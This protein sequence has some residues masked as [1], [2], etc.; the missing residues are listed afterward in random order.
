MPLVRITSVDPCGSSFLQAHSLEVGTCASRQRSRRKGWPSMKSV[1]IKYSCCYTLIFLFVCATG[2]AQL[3]GAATITPPPSATQPVVSPDTL[4][5]DTPRG[6]VLNFL[7]YAHRGD[8]ATAAK[9][10]QLSPKSADDPEAIALE[11]LTLL[12]TSFRGS[13][14]LVS[15]LPEGSQED[16]SEPKSEL[17]GNFIVADQTVPFTLTRVTQKKGAGPVWLVSKETLDHV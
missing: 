6:T 7:K 2:V 4:H 8:Y 11:L 13:I 12:D 17:V 10:L 3:P 5:R 9:Y 1:Q 14:S 16:L 15:D